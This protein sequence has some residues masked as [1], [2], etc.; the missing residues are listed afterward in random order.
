MASD[1]VQTFTY[2]ALRV[3]QQPDGP[4]M[5]LLSLDA[6]ELLEWAD[7]PNAKADYMAGYQRVYSEDRAKAITDFLNLDPSNVIPGAVIV[8]ISDELCKV[9]SHTDDGVSRLEVTVNS[10][11]FEDR[12]AHIYSAFWDR[13]SEAE[14]QSLQT[15]GN[16]GS[17]S[18]ESDHEVEDGGIPDSYI[19][20]LTAE[21]KLATEDL[22]AL[23][24]DRRAAI[25]N[26]VTSVSKPGLII[27]GQHRVFGAKDVSQHGIQLPI[28]LLP[29]LDVAEQV[30]HFYVLNNKAKPLSPTELRRTIATSLTNQ[31]I[32][33]LWTRFEDAGV[34]P[35]ATRW[36][37]KMN[38]DAAS[39]FRG[40]ID[41][42]LG[43]GG[44][45]KENVAYQVV[46]KFV[47]MPRKYRV[48]YKD[49]T[50][51]QTKSDDRLTYFYALWQAVRDRYKDV[52]E[53]QV[54]NGGGQLVQKAAMLVLQEFVLDFMV[55]V[56]A[57]RQM[58]G[59]PSPL[60]DVDDLRDVVKGALTYLPPEFFSTEWQEKQL[61][62][63]ERRAF[64]RDQ[65]QKA[66]NNQGKYLGTLTLFKKS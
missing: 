9:L 40:L 21:L 36:T 63:T 25:E 53:E 10:E 30:F 12:L 27:D 22:S 44:F 66:V 51:W 60:A 38:N 34:D 15:S 56:M 4:P 26:Y 31:E 5:Y 1:D 13:L 33:R 62:T 37:H 52:W 43:G 6:S 41:F 11:S 23:P 54:S 46:S 17:E 55:Q 7:V 50:S 18:E 61:D 57:V 49:I 24:D 47:N 16:G 2:T 58:E 48:L 3:Q 14:R 59:K 39:P 42:G 65:M 20:A 45:I 19:A 64:L 8:A 35:E 28:V 29:G 32:D